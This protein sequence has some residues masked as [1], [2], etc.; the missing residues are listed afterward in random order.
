MH[1]TLRIKIEI[2][3]QFSRFTASHTFCS[4]R[5]NFP[6][7]PTPKTLDLLLNQRPPL[8]QLEQVHAQV[9]TKSLS[10]YSILI[11]SL[12]HCYLSTNSL[13]IAR[14]LFD[15]YPNYPPPILL[16]N[17]V[18]RSY[19]KLPNSLEPIS[20]FCRLNALEDDPPVI[21]DKFTFTFLITSCTHQTSELHGLIVHGIVTKNGYLSNLY[22]GNS[23]INLYGVF[24][25]LDDACKVF[26]EMSERDVFSWTSLLGGH[27]KQGEMDKASEI[28]AMMPL[29]NMISWTVIISGFLDC[30]KYIKALVCFYD[31]LMESHDSLKPNEAVL[32]CALSAC[33]PLGALDQGNSIHAY[34][35]KSG[36]TKRS[37]I[38]TALIDMYA[39]CGTIN[40][41]YQVFHKI[42][43]PDVCNYTSMISGFSSHGLG[44][45]ALQVFHQML[46]ENIAPN[47]VT[48]L[49]VLTGCSHSGLVEE[50]SSIF[51]K[52]ASMWNIAA[53]VEHYG[54]YV[55]LLGRAGYLKTA[56]LIAIKMPLDADIVIWRAL[57]S[58]CRIYKD[59]SL[60]D[61]I[62]AYVRQGYF[63]QFDGSEVLLSNLYAS[64]NTWERVGE[65][66]KLM[67][68]RK[69]ESESES[70]SKSNFGCSWIEVNGVVHDFRVDD[71]LHPQIVMVRDKL[72][73]VKKTPLD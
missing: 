21:A 45:N 14:T 71:Q 30:G 50:G 6:T 37:N 69:N 54:C 44:G 11:D 40:S 4:S 52:M 65:V 67:S 41:A 33:S 42:S 63:S 32:V 27:A 72:H 25:R 5:V 56:L 68:Q 16:W 55:D 13:T 26:D 31:M 58:A 7:N 66:R 49:G 17:L 15:Q 51:H 24:A 18:I 34:I 2:F 9:I 73:K 70:E 53:K 38:S 28:F 43:Q 22:V 48:L 23:L 60:A 39:K 57:L 3:K 59:V 8:L 35:N 47:E 20:L 62:I 29:R 1:G 61:K 12:I 19:S 36:F 46:A 10:S 64:L